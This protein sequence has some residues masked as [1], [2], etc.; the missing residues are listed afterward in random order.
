[1]TGLAR[2]LAQALAA[3]ETAVL[4]T[5]AEALGSTPRE[6]G[7]RMLV[8]ARRT[9]GT[10]GGG[11]LEHEAVAAARR[12]IQTGAATL[13]MDLPLGPAIGQCCGGHVGL[14]LERADAGALARLERLEGAE[15]DGL[16]AICLFGA[17]HV[18]KAIA[19]ALAPLPLRLTWIDS[20]AEEFPGTIP[21]GVVQAI[22]ADPLPFVAQAEPG[23]CFLILTH[24]H[25]L[26]FALAAAA[27][28]RGDA[29][30]VGLIGSRTKRRK[31]ERLYAAS[32][33]RPGDLARL[34]CPIGAGLIRDKRP[35]VIAA[36]VAAEL[37]I[38][39]DR[40]ANRVVPISAGD[41][42]KEPAC[43]THPAGCGT[44]SD[45]TAGTQRRSAV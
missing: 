25:A 26:D 42:K 4:V 9:N 2:T 37:L 35:A 17:G 5:V 21:E 33:G 34:T 24:D 16:P 14:R 13:L 19:Q 27:L 8:S 29:R 3:G 7:A 28:K 32:G 38:A 44:C 36:M 6:A 40:A 15:R 43:L 45:A 41:T 1:M 23:T 12:L 20:R 39:I 10:I 22:A 31:F 11:R 30:Y 18:G